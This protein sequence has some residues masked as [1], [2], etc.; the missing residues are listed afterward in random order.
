MFIGHQG[1]ALAAKAVAPRVPLG[2]LVLAANWLDLIWPFLLLA[3]LET[4]AIEPR[5]QPMTPLAFVSYPYSHSLLFAAGW[6]VVV[7]GIY[8]A[9]R[10]DIRGAVVVG[11]LVVSHWLL[12]LIVH[13]PDLPF[14]PGSAKVG[15]GL[16]NSLPATLLAEVLVFV[17]GVIIYATVTRARDGIGRWS[18]L[19]FVVFLV[20]MYAAN[21]LGPPPPDA[22]SLAYFALALWLIPLWAWWIGRH[23]DPA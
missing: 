8:G 19:A 13:R 4:V 17:P 14:Y 23:R 22:R 21:V 12:D 20:I 1:I 9:A 18:Y 6:G 3:G 15:L 11:L 2:V 10:K 7:G 16:W 5:H